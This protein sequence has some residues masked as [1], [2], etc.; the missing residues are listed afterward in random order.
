MRTKVVVSALFSMVLA[1]AGCA[2]SGSG[3]NGG[4]GN[5][6]GDPCTD[7]ATRC[8]GNTFEACTG[9]AWTTADQC[10]RFCDPD[11]GCVECNA[12][13]NHCV[14]N[15]VYACDADGKTAGLVDSCGELFCENGVCADL[16]A[17]AEASR[18]YIGCEY[19]AVDLQNAIEV[20]PDA[21]IDF[22]GTFV[23]LDSLFGAPTVMRND[24]PVCSSGSTIQGE[25]ENGG[26]CPGSLTCAARPVCV[27]DAQHS[28]FAIVVSNPHASRT[29]AV[30]ISNRAGDSHA[31]MV[32]PGQVT[33]FYPQDMGFADQSVSGSGIEPL[34]Y[35]VTSNVPIVAY[36]FNP[37]DNVD[38][39][40]NDGS[41][42]IPRH[43]FDVE[44][45]ALTWPTL[46]RRPAK[47]DYSGYVTVVA[48]EDDTEVRVT[49]TADVRPGYG[50]FAAIPAG[51]PTTFTLDAFEVLNLQAGPSGDL[52]GTRIESVNG[53]TTIGVFA[54]HEALVIQHGA[55]S[56]CA[57]HVE[58]MMFPT[59]TWGMDYAVARSKDRGQNEADVI[60]IL[61]QTDGT[62]VTVN[63]PQGSC[64]V[65]DAG[66]FCT[67]DIMGDV[68]IT[69]NQPI[70]VGH[71]LKSVIGG[72]LFGG[73]GTGD[74][75]L[76]L[77]VP[78]EQYRSTYTFLVPQH[79]AQQYISVVAPA[80][81]S[82]TLDGS[83]VSGQFATFGSG[84][85]SAARI[86]VQ[87]GQRKLDCAGGC[88]LTVYGYDDAVSYMFPGGLDLKQIVID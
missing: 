66:E 9:G 3:G 50:G 20:S 56:C 30:T 60:R 88:G 1:L 6:P 24:I 87:P 76:S 69:A 29:A 52:T 33:A 83:D 18:S 84:T 82:V 5:Q 23:C 32:D 46:D 85:W 31:L 41:L 53:V 2:D 36:Q 79:Y 17:D 81:G 64:P 13:L 27:L 19:F 10:S 34:A 15:D 65:L 57:D 86:Q 12:G 37:L 71:Y 14:G 80:G 55:S 54:G 45:L 22:F 70:L 7:G 42:L 49:P 35:R 73:S 38:V 77:A 59:S 47:N 4:D 21:P 28:P 48:W 44:Y 68:E 16:C 61:A 74:P 72:G 25:C 58:S 62:Q 43:A 75:A 39:F 63:P 78:S 26:Q 51:T 40:S 8:T 11:A 67:F